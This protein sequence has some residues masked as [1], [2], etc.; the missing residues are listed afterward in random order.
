MGCE[1]ALS[2]ENNS[3]S[4]SGDE[5]IPSPRVSSALVPSRGDTTAGALPS[6]PVSRALARSPAWLVA[7]FDERA[8]GSLTVE[9]AAQAADGAITHSRA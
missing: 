9:V 8:S 1:E 7:A 4:I 5:A 3:A 6:P 2:R